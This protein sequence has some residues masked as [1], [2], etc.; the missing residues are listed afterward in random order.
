MLLLLFLFGGGSGDA[1]P[2]VLVLVLVLAGPSDGRFTTR[3]GGNLISFT[4]ASCGIKWTGSFRSVVEGDEDDMSAVDLVLK[5]ARVA[6]FIISSYTAD[7][8]R[9]RAVTGLLAEL[10]PSSSGLRMC[11]PLYPPSPAPATGS[12]C[13]NI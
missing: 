3:I 11:V 4:V 7:L 2:L 9:A 6:S 12:R 8:L 13:G 5:Y 1:D 10:A